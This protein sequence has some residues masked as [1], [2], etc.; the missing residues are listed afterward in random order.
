[1]RALDPLRGVCDHVAIAWTIGD[2]AARRIVVIE[3]RHGF[4]P[5]ALGRPPLWRGTQPEWFRIVHHGVRIA[6]MTKP[7]GGGR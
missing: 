5:M 4:T 6:N 1:V 2:W 7:E 3:V